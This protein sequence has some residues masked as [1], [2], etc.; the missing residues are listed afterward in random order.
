MAK[1]NTIGEAVYVLRLDTSRF[2][3]DIKNIKNTSQKAFSSIADTA[4]KSAKRMEKRWDVALTLI[5][6][7]VDRAYNKITDSISNSI[8]GAIDR[9]DTL[10]N[11]NV[12]FESMG[13]SAESVGSSLNNLSEYLN[14]LPTS[15]TDAVNGV[16]L[17]SASFGGIDKGTEY[18]IAMNDAALAFGATSDQAQ[19]AINQLSQ[20]SLEGPLDAE[21]WNSLRDAGF[22]PV[23]AAMAQEAGMTV[24]ELKADFGGYGTKS[25]QDFLDML[26]QLDKDGTG[27]MQSL[28]SIARDNTN[29][30]GTAL[31]NVQ[32]RANKAIGSVLDAIGQANISGAINSFSEQFGTLG[33]AIAAVLTGEGD[34]QQLVQQFVDGIGNAFTTVLPELGTIVGKILPIL[35]E[36]VV[37]LLPP[38]LEGLI[39]G[40][41][42]LFI[43][44]G[45]ML[46]SLMTTIIDTI[47]EV[48]NLLLEPDNFNAILNAFI[49]VIMG[50][51]EAIPQIVE[52][53][54]QAIPMIINAITS[55]LT[56]GNSIML[57]INA[58]ITLFFA[59]IDA[60]PTIIQSLAN[61]LPSIIESIINF[62]TSPDTVTML[63]EAAVTLFLALVVAVPKILAALLE[64]FG[65][66]IGGLWNGI[67]TMFGTFAKNF[68]EF[69]GAI[70]KG[71]LN[72]VL[73]FI[74][75]FLNSP[76]KLINGFIGIINN[77]FGWLGINLGSIDLI[78]LPRMYTGGIVPARMGGMPIIAGDGG[79]DEWVVPE[80][81]MASLVEQ[82]RE[83]GQS[84]GNTY[85][86][87]V[88]GVFATS[89]SERRRVADQIVEAI[90]QNNRSRF[91][92]Y[93]NS[94]R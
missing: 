54:T 7:V 68:G 33:N 71:A 88:D 79:E 49:Q 2:S 89:A 64:A 19:N 85:N 87:Y 55:L 1:S 36:A 53:L 32:N 24:G 37:K 70:F 43:E 59:L 80:S 72:G 40:A 67:T 22:G 46:P 34:P 5:A 93:S 20:L 29:G 25:V 42:N 48:F 45:K 83:R 30:I 74:E 52:A 21:T 38:L 86:I 31:E 57:L 3:N 50:V 81:K 58:S 6:S 62:L 11:A 78:S 16:Q 13:Y 76:I 18:F 77:A 65:S 41:A 82:L 35:L 27:S 8:S 17:L 51:V 28:S 26:I 39:Q 47:I 4:D 56:D 44:L 15:M 12:V 10:N 84:T 23:F 63:I 14:G 66:L 60:I 91:Y 92:D 75:N 73:S 9:V 94:I 61:A 69:L 90:E